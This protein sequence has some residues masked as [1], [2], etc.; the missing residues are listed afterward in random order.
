MTKYHIGDQVHA[1]GYTWKVKRIVGMA[2]DIR[3]V[4]KRVGWRY[5]EVLHPGQE[6][7]RR[8]TE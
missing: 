6:T 8:M 1:R 5:L 3:L 7:V 4:V 2:N